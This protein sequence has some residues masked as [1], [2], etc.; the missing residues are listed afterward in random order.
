[1]SEHAAPVQVHAPAP[2]QQQP[3]NSFHLQRKCMCGSY[4]GGGGECDKCRDEGKKV[5][6]VA[7]N[8]STPNRV[9][10]IV[11][12]VLGSSGQSLDAATRSFMEPRF[13]HDF[14]NVRVHTDT[15]AAQSAQAV[16][17]LA[18][19]VGRDVVFGA[20]QYAPG[21]VRGS[22]LLAHELTHVVQQ[23]GSGYNTRQNAKP[24][25]DP[26][27]AAE[28]E[29]DDATSKIFAGEPF[30]PVRQPP[31][32]TIHALSPEE[33][34]WAIFGGVVG[35]IGI[36]V[37]IAALA[38]AFSSN[39]QQRAAND[40]A[41]LLRRIQPACQANATAEQRQAA[42]NAL[43][44]WA[45]PQSSLGIDWSRIDWVHYDTSIGAKGSMT[46]AE[47]TNHIKISLG[48]E[49]FSSPENLYSTFR[50]ELVHVQE[51]ETRPRSEIESRGI[52]VQEIYAYLWELEHQNETGLARRENWGLRADGTADVSKGLARVVD[53]VFRALISMADDLG[54]NPSAVPMTEQIAIER[55]V[56]C[57]MTQTPREVVQA[58][59][60]QAPLDQWRRECSEGVQTPQPKL[61]GHASLGM[62]SPESPAEREA[63]H[64]ANRI[65]HGWTT[66]S[67]HES[68]PQIG[69]HRSA[70][71]LAGFGA[72]PTDEGMPLPVPAREFFETGFGRSFD[73]VRIHT[74]A[75]AARSAQSFQADAFTVGRDIYFG[76]GK[77]DSESTGGRHLIAHE[78]THTI[79]QQGAS[80]S[81][82]RQASGGAT[83]SRGPA[84]SPS[85]SATPSED[86]GPGNY[87]GCPEPQ[88][89]MAA[90][91]DAAARVAHAVDVLAPA[92]I[93]RAASLLRKHFHVDA[94]RPESQ[95]TIA[96]IRAQF[97]RMAA[98]LNSGIR[99]FC[100]SVPR[101]PGLGRS[102][103]PSSSDCGPTT[104]ASS[105][106]C[107]NNDPSATVQL[108]EMRIIEGGEGLVKTV[109]HEFA[110]IACD[111][112]P[113][114]APAG[115]E[116]Y[117]EPPDGLSGEVPDVIINADSYA[118]FAMDAG[119]IHVAEPESQTGGAR[120]SGRSRLPWLA[121]LGVGLGLGIGG[122]FAPGLL[123]GA[124]LGV[125]I[126][127]AGLAGAFE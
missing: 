103:M 39:D 74:D 107:A 79:Q 54:A 92:N 91:G 70:T 89:I 8:R 34:D 69:V 97:T 127:I 48:P 66:A 41:D 4:A 32:A 83:P 33:R 38:G 126:G 59:L 53:G 6:R 61:S 111:G 77:F 56:A 113:A 96:L 29:A 95:E 57:A 21:T 90:R 35:A 118:H 100:R 115:V 13:G 2:Q 12:D 11:N 121:V 120:R 58:V 51:H 117:Y 52:G 122:I 47:D 3:A 112:N 98:G 30:V 22:Q 72:I 5:E 124:A 123:V 43:V 1:M 60:P 87:D 81:I 88:P 25:S 73:D 68:I 15:R 19:T 114:I 65:A 62:S 26:S 55:R 28:V 102:Q 67:I 42:V 109:I 99:I 44:A 49:A 24:I 85:T 9:P 16:N 50:H 119:S 105:T 125:G 84:A 40:L 108:C 101:A 106:S 27:D 36:G 78:L 23:A 63:D 86:T 80:Q 18:Y 94:S 76:A 93:S 64:I 10:A 46:D 37:G 45:R 75:P 71:G 31:N 116:R 82:M 14:S 104:R 17:A 20:G 7:I 110:H